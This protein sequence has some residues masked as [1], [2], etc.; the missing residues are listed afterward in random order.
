M[1]AFRQFI[2]FADFILKTSAFQIFIEALIGFDWF[3]D[4]LHDYFIYFFILS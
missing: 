2:L 4:F 1:L 3:C